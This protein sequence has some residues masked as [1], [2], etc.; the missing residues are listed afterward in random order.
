MFYIDFEEYIV[1]GLYAFLSIDM[2]RLGSR[3]ARPI[4]FVLCPL[5]LLNK[6]RG[7]QGEM[8]LEA[9]NHWDL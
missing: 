7:M 8:Q 3:S 4:A 2:V 1:V 5:N 6:L 9:L